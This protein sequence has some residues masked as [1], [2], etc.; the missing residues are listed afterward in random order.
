MCSQGLTQTLPSPLR[1]AG[2]DSE[3]VRICLHSFWLR[4]C[5]LQHCQYLPPLRAPPGK[6]VFSLGQSSTAAVVPWPPWLLGEPLLTFSKL[7]FLGEP[8]ATP[9]GTLGSSHSPF[10]QGRSSGG[11]RRWAQEV[12]CCPRPPVNSHLLWES[13]KAPP[14]S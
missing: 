2:S 8:W 4:S 10:V 13:G 7:G 3:A 5:C 12:G 14:W 9:P 6:C 1:F 11:L